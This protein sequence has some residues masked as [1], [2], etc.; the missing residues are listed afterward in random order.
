VIAVF[1]HQ[2]ATGLAVF[3]LH[4]LTALRDGT[5]PDLRAVDLGRFVTSPPRKS[6]WRHRCRDCGKWLNWQPQACWT[7]NSLDLLQAQ[8]KRRQPASFA[9]FHLKLAEKGADAEPK[10]AQGKRI[11]PI[12]TPSQKAR[13]A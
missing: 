8:Q 4:E 7:C 2:V 5:E 1:W 9:T 12:L 3:L 6:K 13:M 10:R 11:I